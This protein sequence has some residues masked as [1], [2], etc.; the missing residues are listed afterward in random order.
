MIKSRSAIATIAGAALVLASMPLGAQATDPFD[1]N[2]RVD[3]TSGEQPSPMSRYVDQTQA[4]RGAVDDNANSNRADTTSAPF[5]P[6][7]IR[8]DDSAN[9]ATR[10]G[11]RS[12]VDNSTT[13]APL[14][15]K[16]RKP[17]EFESFASDLTGKSIRRFGSELLI[18]EA[19]DFIM[20]PTTAVPPDYRVNPGDEIVLGL[21]GGVQ[22]DNVRL[23]VDPEG[24][25]FIPKVGAV[26]VGG[27]P[28]RDLQSAV[29]REVSRQYRGFTASVT[30]GRLHGIT[31]YV[32][33]FAET[34]GS[35][36]VSSLSTLINAVLS[37]GGP[38]AGGSF[39][40]IQ[41][42]REGR[43]ISDFDL[44]DFL[45]KG[46]KSGDVVLQNG[47]VIF[48]APAGA[49]VAV[50]GSVNSEAIYEAKAGDTLSDVLLYAGGA[51]TVAD[52]GRLHVLDPM[53][54]RGW[55]EI[56]PQQARSEPVRRGQVLRVL[57]GIGI[58]LPVQRLQALV[59][60][61]GEV[62][63]PGR[64]F[65]KPGTTLDDVVAMAGGLTP[66][67]YPFG[68]V[69]VRDS[70]RRQQKINFERAVDEVKVTLAAQPLVSATSQAVDVGA[71]MAAVNS[72][73]EQLRSRRIDG[74]LVMEAD[75]A[76]GLE[77]DFVVENN[78]TLYVPP[79]TVAVGVYGMVNGS[80]D[81]RYTPG[82]RIRDYLRLAGGFNRLADKNHIFV[83]RANGML[84]SRGSAE[85][86]EA[87]PGD[88]VFVPV[89]AQRGE[90][91]ARM[92]DITATLF[93]GVAAAASVKVLTD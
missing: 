77:G 64:Y 62:E 10:D 86:A 26:R 66:Q 58:A 80:A 22:A 6:D 60:V 18:P 92:R 83:V 29:A 88:L 76:A 30:M 70:L 13:T 7:Q 28:Y 8:S 50:I 35:Y 34:P 81:F 1:P 5:R 45:L 32:T 71:R 79:R 67:A 20:P 91:W 39:R 9:A 51:N 93:S 72:L 40:S 33:G 38:S 36:T 27:L 87:L 74:R 47:D 42:R 21:T 23:T 49:Q 3:S 59:T 48:I 78:D 53:S 44:Y 24:R 46:D 55:Q 52:L 63:K 12:S 89:D 4:S 11:G 84:L 15:A 19:R 17:S 57:S 69:F 41:V 61:S 90:F 14:R 56:A 75:P 54:D 43:L 16:P 25:I 85:N 37:A 73:V 31:V 65:V 82:R 68:A 2:V